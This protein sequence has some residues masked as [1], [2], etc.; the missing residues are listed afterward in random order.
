MVIVKN[1]EKVHVYIRDCQ[2]KT[3]RPI[4]GPRRRKPRR[5]VGS[6][7]PMCFSVMSFQPNSIQT[8]DGSGRGP[9]LRDHEEQRKKGYCVDSDG[10]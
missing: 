9:I 1:L 8:E 4:L 7:N 6:L 10:A 3:M 2:Q 5:V